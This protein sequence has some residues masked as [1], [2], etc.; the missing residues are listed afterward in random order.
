MTDNTEAL[1]LAEILSR[2]KFDVVG[3]ENAVAVEE[4]AAELRRLVAE[5]EALVADADRYRWLRDMD[6]LDQPSVD[7]ADAF[8]KYTGSALDA[9]I[10]AAMRGE[11]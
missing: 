4:A 10:D 8:S 6:M 2:L 7:M 5:N 1:R 9:A 11:K 3:A